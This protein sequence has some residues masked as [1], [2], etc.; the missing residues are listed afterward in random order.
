MSKNEVEETQAFWN[1]VASDWEIQVTDTG[2]SNRILNSDPVL[3]DF[4][5][6]VAGLKVLDAG[7]GTGYLSRKLYDRGA[8]VIGIDFSEKMIEIAVEGE[9]RVLHSQKHELRSGVN[10]IAVVVEEDLHLVER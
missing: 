2:D 5:G 7:C 8:R 3:W 10:E 4:A 6:D 1:R 9:N